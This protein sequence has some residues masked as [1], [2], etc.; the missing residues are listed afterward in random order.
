[1]AKYYRPYLTLAQIRTLIEWCEPLATGTKEEQELYNK[2][3]TLEQSIY[4]ESIKPAHTLKTQK[5]PEPKEPQVIPAKEQRKLAYDKF[6]SNSEELTV[7]EFKLVLLYRYENDLM[8]LEEEAE[9]ENEMLVNQG[10][11]NNQGDLNND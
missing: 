9:Y 6:L 4:L 1:M 8:S 10:F 5:H 3:L 11:A 2:F 7:E